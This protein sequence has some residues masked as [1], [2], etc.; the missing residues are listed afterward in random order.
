MTLTLAG[1][2]GDSI[3]LRALTLGR[4]IKDMTKYRGWISMGA[5]IS[6]ALIAGCAAHHDSNDTNDSSGYGKAEQPLAACE[7]DDPVYDFN[8]YAAS[9][10][11]AIANE[12]GRWD[13][14]ADF[15]VSN[16]KLVLSAT[17]NLRCGS[18]CGNIKAILQLQD[19]AT[20]IVPYHSPSI[21]RQKL[22]GW[23][24]KQGEKLSALV[25]AMLRVD[26]GIYKLKVRHS[27]KYMAVDGSS[28]ADGAVIEQQSSVHYAGA[29]QWRVKLEG[30]KHK[31]VNVRSGK[32]LS[33]SSDSASNGVALVQRTCS[34]STLQQ[35]D[36]SE[37]SGA[38]AIR[39]KFGLALDVAGASLS[40][41]A[42]VQQYLWRGE[43]T[44]QQW[45]FEPV[46][47]GAHLSPKFV[48]TAVYHLT[49]KHSGKALGVDGGTLS[50]GAAIEQYT[51]TASDD[52]FHWYVTPM[53]DR[54]QL[55]NRRSGKCLALASESSTG[56]LV[57]KAC[58]NVGSQLFV[59]NPASDHQ[60]IYS[61]YGKPLE[62]Q[63]ASTANDARVVQAVEGGW[64]H[65][66]QIKLTP[67]IAGEPHRLRFSH[68]SPE[69]ECGDYHWY[70]IAQPNGQPLRAPADSY[71][72]LIF[73]GGK[74]TLTGAD[75]NPFIA[76]Q[77]SGNK[78][79]IDPTY[80]LNEGQTTTAGSCTYA[81]IVFDPTRLM[82]GQCCVR[83]DGVMS[84]FSVSPFSTSVYLCR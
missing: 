43:S 66:R 45:V 54:H 29:D 27:N 38:Y 17:G 37:T 78:V 47:A 4:R 84:K 33:L 55:V 23:Y 73:A 71:V 21:F 81:N 1:R 14:S 77:V 30:T 72:Q 56:A 28:T 11:I 50:D 65:H 16:G 46:G 76:Q 64:S 61:H 5:L 26:K 22:T 32:C 53:G 75:V 74:E 48:A 68:T 59:F 34:T 36:F 67:V 24:Q 13:V 58:A 51:Y 25:D 82:S 41:D 40:N 10:A 52:R 35:F 3:L 83:S 31:F 80:G 12:L 8:A 18:G 6:G 57:Q 70:D 39:T 9:L 20:S 42:R 7:G 62:V 49:F 2:R 79:A 44:N 60:V 63:G 15:A 69:A 19:D